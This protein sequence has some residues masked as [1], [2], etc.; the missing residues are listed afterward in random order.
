MF[1]LPP[2]TVGKIYQAERHSLET[3]FPWNPTDFGFEDSVR[4]ET[5]IVGR[6]YGIANVILFSKILV[7]YHL[8]A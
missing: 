6:G 1:H 7:Q 2:T 4:E 5:P 8:D 3:V